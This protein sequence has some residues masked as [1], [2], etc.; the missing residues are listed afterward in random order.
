LNPQILCSPQQSQVLSH[1]LRTG[2]QHVLAWPQAFV[3][4]VLPASQQ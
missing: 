2:L 1:P 4:Q 3:S